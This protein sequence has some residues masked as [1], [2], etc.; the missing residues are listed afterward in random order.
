MSAYGKAREWF[1]FLGTR[2]GADAANEVRRLVDRLEDANDTV[3]YA[4]RLL[5]G[6]PG[7]EIEEV[8]RVARRS[9][10]EGISELAQVVLEIRLGD[11]DAA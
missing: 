4:L 7:E 8:L 10:S 9:I 2:S 1:L 5:T 3:N 11:P 6:S